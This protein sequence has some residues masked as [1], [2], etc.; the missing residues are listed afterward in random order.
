MVMRLPNV[1]EHGQGAGHGGVERGHPAAK[2][3][4]RD[5]IAFFFNQASK[6]RPF[7]AHDQT[8]LSIQIQ[9]IE[10][11]LGFGIGP[12]NP[13]TLILEEIQSPGHICHSNHAHMFRRPG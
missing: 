4:R 8:Q 5:L 13:E 7:S 10:T 9:I 1:F 3:K 11:Y 12:D 2:G 6:A